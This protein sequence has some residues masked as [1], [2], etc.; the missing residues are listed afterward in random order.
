MKAKLLNEAE[1]KTWAVVLDSGDEAAACLL[2]FAQ[3]HGV[4]AASLSA[5]GGFERA[6]LGFFDMQTKQYR[7]IPVDQQMEVLSLSGDITQ[8]GD[9]TDGKAKVHAHVVVGLADGSTRG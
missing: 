5:V 9:Q 4:T 1:L 8:A 2:N 6:V 7:Q 3:E